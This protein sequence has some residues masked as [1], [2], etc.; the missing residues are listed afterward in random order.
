MLFWNTLEK[1]RQITKTPTLSSLKQGTTNGNEENILIHTVRN[2]C[3]CM[4]S[5]SYNSQQILPCTKVYKFYCI[6][7]KD[8][9]LLV[10]LH[11][12]SKRCSLKFS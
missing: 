10:S 8:K 12:N 2:S 4:G 11:L 7:F 9:L 6:R 1:T 3:M 5:P